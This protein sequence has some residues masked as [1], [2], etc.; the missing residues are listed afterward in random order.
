MICNKDCFHCTF[1]DCVYDGMDLDDYREAAE[2]DR[3]LKDSEKSSRQRKIAAKQKAYYEANRDEIA[4][5]QKAYREAN[6][7]ENR[8]LG[9]VL[10]K[11]RKAVGLPQWAVADWLSVSRQQVS[12][13]ESGR[14]ACD[15][16]TFL[17]ALHMLSGM[18]V[19]YIL[20]E[21]AA[22]I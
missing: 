13:F 19:D 21:G 5:K 9:S 6:R 20:T 18:S 3:S 7:D 10:Q 4:A 12:H 14:A 8:L 2:R 1:A 17:D 16:E 11:C 22:I 15:K